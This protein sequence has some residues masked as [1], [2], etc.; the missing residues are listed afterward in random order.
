MGSLGYTNRADD[1]ERASAER[2]GRT[3]EGQQDNLGRPK[4]RSRWAAAIWGRILKLPHMIVNIGIIRP[5]KLE[6]A[7]GVRL[8]YGQGKEGQK[9]SITV[10][11]MFPINELVLVRSRRSGMP[12]IFVHVDGSRIPC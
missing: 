1:D 7:I 3:E 12:A 8:R 5:G 4:K 2:Q 10:A 9:I 11:C 6:V